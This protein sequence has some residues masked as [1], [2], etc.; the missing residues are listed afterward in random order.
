[1]PRNPDRIPVMMR[2]P[3]DMDTWLRARAAYTTA[4]ISSECIRIIRAAMDA[5]QPEQRAA[6]KREAAT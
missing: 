4:S 6:R 2:V 5:E 3:P 1:M